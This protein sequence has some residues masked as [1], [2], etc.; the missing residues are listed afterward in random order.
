MTREQIEQ[1][2][3]LEPFCFETAREEQWYKVG[4]KE[5]L[6]TADTYPKSSPWISV[7]DDLPCNHKEFIE[8]D[9]YTKPVLAVLTQNEDPSKKQIEVCHMCDM[10]DILGNICWYWHIGSHYQVAYWMP[11]PKMSN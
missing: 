10:F 6:E 9:H 7:E 4:L 1:L 2:N 3:E 5:G 8:D 11:L